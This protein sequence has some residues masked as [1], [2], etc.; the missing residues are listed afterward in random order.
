MYD[1]DSIERVFSHC[2][3]LVNVEHIKYPQY[4]ELCSHHHMSMLNL[5]EEFSSMNV[6]ELYYTP[7]PRQHQKQVHLHQRLKGGKLMLQ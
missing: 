4:T 7:Q 3:E 6:M 5:S 1:L 2:K